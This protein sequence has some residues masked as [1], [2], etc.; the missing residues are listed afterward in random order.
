MVLTI[1]IRTDQMAGRPPSPSFS[2]PVPERWVRCPFGCAQGRLLPQFARAGSSAACIILC[3]AA[4]PASQ[5]R[6]SSP[7]LYHLLV[8]SAT[9]V[10][11]HCTQPRPL[12]LDS[13]TDRERYRFVRKRKLGELGPSAASLPLLAKDARNGAPTELLMSARSKP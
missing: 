7:A 2:L 11:A 4:R 3:H 9:A 5:L 13:G 6:R 10:S 12:P 1:S 8:L